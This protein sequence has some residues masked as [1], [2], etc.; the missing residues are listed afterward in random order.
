MTYDN[1]NFHYPH[2]VEFVN[3]ITNLF[4]ILFLPALV[5][6]TLYLLYML[7][8][9]SKKDNHYINVTLVITFIALLSA[10]SFYAFFV[11]DYLSLFGE[12]IV[13]LMTTLMY[14][15]LSPFIL[16]HTMLTTD[17]IKQSLFLDSNYLMNDMLRWL[18]VKFSIQ[19]DTITKESIFVSF[20]LLTLMLFSTKIINITRFIISSVTH[21]ASNKATL[22][23]LFLFSLLFAAYV[24]LNITELTKLY[25]I[26]MHVVNATI[27]GGLI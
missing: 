24:Y 17:D 3:S 12:A 27:A 21:T 13:S 16:L 8:V 26:G 6:L 2:I 10:Y 19:L 14:V 4:L 18:K 5:F 11:L 1:Y 20:K 7:F 15:V 25:H 23:A 22:T 9:S